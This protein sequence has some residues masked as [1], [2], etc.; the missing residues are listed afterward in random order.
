M[1]LLTFK[2]DRPISDHRP[3][4]VAPIGDIQW[5][6]ERGPTSKDILKRH[7]DRCLKLDAWYI[8]LG[9]YIDFMSPSNRQRF[10]EAG[11]YDTAQDVVD[12]KALELTYELYEKF[13]RPTKGRW[14][15]MLHG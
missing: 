4:F 6:G 2:L 1:E 10:K 11:L 14:L 9:D 8:G 13:L 7:I 12:D 3:I 5:S 15:G